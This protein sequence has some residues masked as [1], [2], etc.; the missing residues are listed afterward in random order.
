[1][2]R[3]VAVLACL[4]L[5]APAFA[6][7]VKKEKV[8]NKQQDRMKACNERAAGKKGEERKRFMST[9]LKGEDETPAAGNSQQNRM[10]ECNEKA[11]GKIG[12]ERKRFM[13]ECLKG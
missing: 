9:C 5:G 11:A 2:R 1:M 13:S 7:E 12:P 3:L 10:K 4:A 8:E 6:E